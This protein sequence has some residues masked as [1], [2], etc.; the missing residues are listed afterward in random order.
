VTPHNFILYSVF[1]GSISV[2]VFV[3]NQASSGNKEIISHISQHGG[4]WPYW[5]KKMGELL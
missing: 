1:Q 4:K 2:F 5:F 3:F